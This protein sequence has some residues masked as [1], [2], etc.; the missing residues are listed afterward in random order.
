MGHK[1]TDINQI[2]DFVFAGN[3][4]FTIRSATSGNHWTFKIQ[5]DKKDPNMN[6]VRLLVAADQYEYLG[7]IKNNQYR[8]TNKSCRAAEHQSHQVI[9]YILDCLRANKLHPKLDFFH[10]GKCGRCG[11]P[12]TDPIS[13]ERGLGPTCASK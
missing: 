6:W 2:R 12:L 9:R 4:V 10:E 8:F 13:I 11:R 1:F 7:Y 5:R 3:A